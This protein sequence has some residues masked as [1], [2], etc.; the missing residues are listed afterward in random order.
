[1]IH[2]MS[3]PKTMYVAVKGLFFQNNRLLLLRK[4]GQDFWDVPGGRI[5]FGEAIDAALQ[6]ELREELPNVTDI[7]L[8]DLVGVR[9]KSTPLEDGNELFLVYYQ[10]QGVV[11]T[12]LKLSDEHCD[13]K[14]FTKEEIAL[15][16]MPFNQVYSEFFTK[17]R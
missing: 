15:L 1:M 16:P 4:T 9:K 13:S 12:Q 17:L 6:R 10:V 8:I 3:K 14:W 11:P 7:S 5:E 2:I